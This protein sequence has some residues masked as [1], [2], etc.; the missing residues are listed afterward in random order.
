MADIVDRN[1]ERIDKIKEC[2]FSIITQIQKMTDF[3]GDLEDLDDPF[4]DKVSDLR[5]DL[6]LAM[7]NINAIE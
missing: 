7:E 6:D 3:A 1:K 4:W 2:A 5:G